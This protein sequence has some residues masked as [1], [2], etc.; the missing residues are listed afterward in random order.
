MYAGRGNGSEAH[1]LHLFPPRNLN[2]TGFRGNG[3]NSDH[4]ASRR[5][6]T[7]GFSTRRQSVPIGAMLASHQLRGRLLHWTASNAGA[8][9]TTFAEH[10][11][12]PSTCGSGPRGLLGGEKMEALGKPLAR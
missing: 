9:I 2:S 6:P 11:P 7:V 5:P 1:H 12:T 4:V 3:N 10:E 8:L